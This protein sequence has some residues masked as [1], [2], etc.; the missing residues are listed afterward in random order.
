MNRRRFQNNNNYNNIRYSNKQAISNFMNDLSIRRVQ[1][2]ER[3]LQSFFRN[4]F[5]INNQNQYSKKDM[6]INRNMNN[7]RIQT[8]RMN[9]RR[10]RINTNRDLR[11]NNS[12]TIGYNNYKPRKIM[13]SNSIGRIRG[14]SNVKNNTYNDAKNTAKRKILINN[15][16]ISFPLIELKKIFGVYG[17]IERASIIAKKDCGVVLFKSNKSAN[18]AKNDLDS[19]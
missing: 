15:L 10:A 5:G 1:R 18:R 12:N 14:L 7:N 13:F 16:D 11:I 17:K 9:R 6:Y 19:K 4:N 3:R 8:R 2:E